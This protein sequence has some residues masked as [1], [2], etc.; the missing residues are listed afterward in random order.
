MKQKTLRPWLLLSPS[1]TAI[2]LM[3]VVPIC[4][5]VVYSF[6]LRSPVGQDIPAFQFGNQR[7][8]WPCHQDQA[9][10]CHRTCGFPAS[11]G[12]VND[13]IWGTQNSMG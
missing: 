6:W 3:L 4:F 7:I 5:V 9:L 10:R 2:L 8:E 1:I 11:G 12:P 13:P